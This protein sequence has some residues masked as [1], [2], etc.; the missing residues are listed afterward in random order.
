MNNEINAFELTDE[1]LDMVAGASASGGNTN[2]TAISLGG[3]TTNVALFASNVS[4]YGAQNSIS[5]S[6]T[7]S[8]SNT[9]NTKIQ[10]W[11]N[12]FSHNS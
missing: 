12:L 7:Q 3:N 8:S 5:N 10:T 1:Q 2:I 9:D 4:Q 11:V 6:N